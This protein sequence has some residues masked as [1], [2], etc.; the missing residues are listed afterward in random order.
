MK[1]RHF[2]CAA[3][4]FA[5]ASP[6]SYACGY[7]VEDR[8]ASVYNHALVSQALARKHQVA[9][10]AINGPLAASSGEQQRIARIAQGGQGVDPGSARVAIETATLAV[11]FDPRVAPLAAVEASLQGKLALKGLS[12]Q[13]LRII[14]RP[15]ELKLAQP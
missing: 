10:F 15:G 5:L 4:A 13:R 6:A 3:L 8:I 9:F 12:V 11:T 14:D 2:L 1:F 7:C